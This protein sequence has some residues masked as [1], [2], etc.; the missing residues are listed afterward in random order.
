MKSLI[1]YGLMSLASAVDNGLG[2]VPPMGWNS[3][4]K[5]GCR[6]SEKLMKAQADKMVE[7]GLDK[8]GYVYVNIDDCW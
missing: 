3:W 5:F 8:L 2:Q 7:F 1:L 4:N 6:V